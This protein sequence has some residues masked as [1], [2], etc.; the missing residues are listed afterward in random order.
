ML[1][2]EKKHYKI[3]V[4]VLKKNYLIFTID[5]K[6]RIDLFVAY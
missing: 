3:K 5:I 2:L 6:F 1:L 4:L